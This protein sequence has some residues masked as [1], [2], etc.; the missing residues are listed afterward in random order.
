M[1]A[2]NSYYRKVMDLLEQSFS[3]QEE[4]LEKVATSVYTCLTAG[5]MLYVF[6][7]GHAHLLAEELFYRAGGLAAVLPILDDQLMLHKSA[8]G[9][10]H[11]E[12]R[13]GYAQNLL[14]KYP[15]SPKDVLIICSNSGRNSV[16]VE[17]AVLAKE[18][19]IKVIALTS[20]QHSLSCQARNAYNLRLLDV[21]DIVLDNFGTIGDASLEMTDGRRCGAT[22][23]VIGAALL[24]AIVC[25]SVEL[26]IENGKS[27]DVYA[28]SNI[29][30][31]DKKN[32]GIIEHY[33]SRIPIL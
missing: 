6:G 19:G 13:S 5:G 12:R 1:S 11:A 26:A 2:I 15:I 9:S 3:R 16:P 8:T 25:R 24:E 22:S 20:V 10:T 18:R 17:M 21:A 14:N 33:Q 23:T 32:E 31:G 7:T 30:A 27:I 29:D 4:A 28:S